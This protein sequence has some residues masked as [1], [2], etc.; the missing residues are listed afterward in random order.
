[1][2]FASSATGRSEEQTMNAL[3]SATSVLHGVAAAAAVKPAA[4]TTQLII[5]AVISIVLIVVLIVWV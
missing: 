4:G 1:M 3:S 2:R 5:A